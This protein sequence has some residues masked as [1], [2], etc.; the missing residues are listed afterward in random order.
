MRLSVH[1]SVDTALQ[2]DENVD[3]Q[4]LNQA[5]RARLLAEPR[6]RLR[7]CCP[8]THLAPRTLLQP[9]AWYSRPSYMSLCCEAED[10]EGCRTRIGLS[11]AAGDRQRGA[12]AV[13]SA[14]Q[15]RTVTPNRGGSRSRGVPWGRRSRPV[16]RAS[17]Q[18]AGSPPM[19]QPCHP[20]VAGVPGLSAVTRCGGRGS[21]KWTVSAGRIAAATDPLPI[22]DSTR[23]AGRHGGEQDEP[24]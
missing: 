11:E 6:S 1:V 16:G 15:S 9:Q 23:P 5:I 24:R 2:W 19:L 22:D 4:Q 10:G 8:E 20:E 13:P 21:R 7:P 12:A 17:N 14:K 3:H 18:P